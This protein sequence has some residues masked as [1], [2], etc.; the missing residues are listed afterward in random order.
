MALDNANEVNRMKL[1]LASGALFVLMAEFNPVASLAKVLILE[2]YIIRTKNEVL[3][4]RWT[5][6]DLS[7]A[8]FYRRFRQRR[9]S[10]PT[11]PMA[12]RHSVAGSGTADVPS[13]CAVAMASGAA[14]DASRIAPCVLNA[15]SISV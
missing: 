8:K 2:H 14:I 13:I 11:A 7:A 5:I 6:N 10:R 3:I 15:L 12:R 4:C 1:L 9:P